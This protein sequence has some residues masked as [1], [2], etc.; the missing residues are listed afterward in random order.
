MPADAGLLAAGTILAALAGGALGAAFGPL[1]SLGLAGLAIVVGEAATIGSAAGESS[2]SLAATVGGDG[3]TALVGLGPALGPH[4]AFAG[5][6][7]AAAYA[8]RKGYLDDD[9]GYHPAKR[10]S[11]ALGSNPDVLAVGAA[12]GVV[13]Y[14]L[15]QLSVQFDAPWDPIAASVV[16]SAL[17]HRVVFGYPVFG[18]LGSG[19]LDMSPY[20][21]GERRMAADGTDDADSLTGRYVVEPWQPAHYDWANV[22]GLGLVVGL[23]GGFVGVA[24]GSYYLAFGLALASLLFVGTDTGNVPV[25]YHMALPASIAAL[26]LPDAGVAVAVVAGGLFG[27]VGGLVGEFVQRVLYAHADTHLDPAFGSILVTS[28]L[29]A[30]LDAAGLFTQ[31]AVPT[32]GLA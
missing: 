16:I 13:G 27:V 15:T 18:S 20:E 17:L 2:S 31:S 6:V 24:T 19:L 9:S 23:F 14:W 8:A 7:A 3:V 1:R 11:V 21:S 28:V 26:A 10:I 12:F 29:I 25:V 32:A 5:G 4:V 22:T 30:A